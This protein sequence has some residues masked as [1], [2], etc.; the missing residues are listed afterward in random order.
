MEITQKLNADKLFIAQNS[1]EI[2]LK[3]IKM[4]MS[5]KTS[6][7]RQK[8]DFPM[9]PKITILLPKCF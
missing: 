1:I 3:Y 5:K 7:A 9:K 2:A 6:K 8:F 4:T